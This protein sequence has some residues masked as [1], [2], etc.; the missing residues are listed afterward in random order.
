MPV[1]SYKVSPFSRPF[2]SCA[3]PFIGMSDEHARVMDQNEGRLR[4]EMASANIYLAVVPTY[5]IPL[6]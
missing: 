4:G 6:T 1:H 3:C 5:S 2:L